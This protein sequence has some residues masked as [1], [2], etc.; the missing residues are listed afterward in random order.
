MVHPT[1]S[2]NLPNKVLQV[3]RTLTDVDQFIG[4]AD[5]SSDGYLLNLDSLIV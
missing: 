5:F 2:K 3:F 4:P 1:N